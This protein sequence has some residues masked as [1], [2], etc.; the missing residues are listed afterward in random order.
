MD[1]CMYTLWRLRLSGLWRRVVYFGSLLVMV[2][3]ASICF[4]YQLW[5]RSSPV[6]KTC[7]KQSRSCFIVSFNWK[8]NIL[9]CIIRPLSTVRSCQTSCIWCDTNCGGNISSVD[10]MQWMLSKSLRKMPLS[11]PYFLCCSHPTVW[12]RTNSCENTLVTL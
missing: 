10:H 8:E 12:R 7:K 5:E 2:H 11:R 1:R 6:K 9:A 4:K 3:L